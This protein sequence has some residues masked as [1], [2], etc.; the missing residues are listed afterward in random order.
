MVVTPRDPLQPAFL[1]LEVEV[2]CQVCGGFTATIA[3]H[4]VL[5]LAQALTEVAQENP[6]LVG[7]ALEA[8]RVKR[9]EWS[10]TNPGPG[11]ERLN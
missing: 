10:G 8:G 4:H 7:N 11:K 5:A 1:I 2:D 3:G 6:G 9:E